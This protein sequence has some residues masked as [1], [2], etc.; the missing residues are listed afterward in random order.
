MGGPRGRMDQAGRKEPTFELADQPNRRASAPAHRERPSPGRSGGTLRA[1]AEARIGEPASAGELGQRRR[2]APRLLLLLALPLL[3]L[4]YLAVEKVERVVTVPGIVR[5]VGETVSIS[6][7]AG[8]RLAR[9]RVHDG[10]FVEAGA[11]LFD[12]DPRSIE[13]ET[14]RRLAEIDALEAQMLRLEAEATDGELRYPPA[15]VERRPEAVQ[16]ETDLFNA[17]R[18]ALARRTTV[19]QEALASRETTATSRR[20]R[21]AQLHYDLVTLRDRADTLGP[22]VVAGYFPLVRY[23][24]VERRIFDLNQE[25]AQARTE[26]GA[27]EQAAEQAESDLDTLTRDWQSKVLDELAAGLAAYEPLRAE[28]DQYIAAL[29]D[30]VLRAPVDGVVQGLAKIVPPQSIDA[31]QTLMTLAPVGDGLVVEARVAETD[32]QAVELGKAARISG[33]ASEAVD[34][35]TIAGEI[36]LVE[37]APAGTAE[38]QSY[39]VEVRSGSSLAT[40]SD[41]RRFRLLPGM[42]VSVAFQAGERTM[43]EMLAE[44][45]DQATEDVLG[46]L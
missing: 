4:L 7:P 18:A 32:I 21:V 12:L 46:R 23:Q 20:E 29:D 11:P 34:F 24:E 6:H 44:R 10:D 16:A 41:G 1:S 15:L 9:L 35:A 25:L 2:R 38:E 37:P 30:P 14:R 39:A 36:T 13:L 45:L 33:G 17:R 42:E 8:G 27:A 40:R 22:L 28:Y 31:G 3:L 19:A 5:P 43:L 26:L